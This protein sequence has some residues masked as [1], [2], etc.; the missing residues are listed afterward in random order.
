MTYRQSLEAFRAYTP[1]I[2]DADKARIFG[3]SLVTLLGRGGVDS[4]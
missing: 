1:F 4:A 3:D 2:P